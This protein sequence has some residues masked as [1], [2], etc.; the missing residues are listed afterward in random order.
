MCMH[1]TKD[2]ENL[3]IADRAFVPKACPYWITIGSVDGSRRN[4]SQSSTGPLRAF[5]A[6]SK[7]GG[8]LARVERPR[9]K[10]RVR[11]GCRAG[12]EP[13]RRWRISPFGALQPG[14]MQPPDSPFH[15]ARR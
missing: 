15:L 5:D 9:V 4:V 13:E 7:R 2:L 11:D 14:S 1:H 10:F 6:A 3:N 12:Q 8:K